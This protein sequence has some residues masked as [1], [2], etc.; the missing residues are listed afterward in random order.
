MVVLRFPKALISHCSCIPEEY[1]REGHD[2]FLARPS[3]LF[4]HHP[5]FWCCII[6]SV[7]S[8]ITYTKKVVFL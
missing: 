3:E 1:L 6:Q 7:E 4:A 2:R 5:V 8:V